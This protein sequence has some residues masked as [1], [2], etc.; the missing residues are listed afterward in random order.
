MYL[1]V[2]PVF[3]KI[4]VYFTTMHVVYTYLIKETEKST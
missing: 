4:V 3:Q 2:A 1:L